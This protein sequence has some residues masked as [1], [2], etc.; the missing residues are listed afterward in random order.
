MRRLMAVG[1]L[2]FLVAACGDD[3]PSG[4]SG[5]KG[6]VA[7]AT[8]RPTPTPVPTLVGLWKIANSGNL[9]PFDGYAI[10]I[11]SHDTR[12]GEVRGRSV[13]K[14][15]SLSGG[16]LRGTARDIGGGRMH[17]DW[18]TDWQYGDS[19]NGSMDIDAGKREMEG[20]V[21]M[22]FPSVGAGPYTFTGIVLRRE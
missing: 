10:E 18:Q 5:D 2:A 16:A 22:E 9:G 6:P 21:K 4:P 7:A 13:W 15:A 12:S 1:I 8:P 19:E 17:L 11:A 20:M 14:W 3:F